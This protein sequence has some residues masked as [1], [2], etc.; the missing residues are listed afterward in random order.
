MTTD[1]IKEAEKW[2]VGGGRTLGWGVGPLVLK[3]INELKR[4]A[5]IVTTY[6]ILEIDS[7]SRQID[8]LE[9]DRDKWKNQAESLQ[10]C[11][12]FKREYDNK[13]AEFDRKWGEEKKKLGQQILMLER[14]TTDKPQC[15]FLGCTERPTNGTP[16]MS[17]YYALT[18]KEHL[19]PAAQ[20]RFR[21]PT[22]KCKHPPVFHEM[23]YPVYNKPCWVCSK[24][25]HYM[26]DDYDKGPDHGA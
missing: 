17:G 8:E 13:W 14:L 12:K 19:P 10:K 18:C 24:C 11:S 1:L 22:E 6:D 16:L 26:G 7:L 9:V 3:L 2:Y 15:D 21:G 25:N 20:I 23:G 4:L 5:S